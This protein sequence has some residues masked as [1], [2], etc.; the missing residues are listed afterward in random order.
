MTESAA[1]DRVEQEPAPQATRRDTVL[2]L[3]QG[4]EWSAIARLARTHGYLVL[5]ARSIFEALGHVGEARPD[6]VM[7]PGDPQGFELLD[8]LRRG[9]SGVSAIVLTRAGD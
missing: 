3:A 9:A 1:L 6:L 8:R 7:L 5:E 4:P 2:V